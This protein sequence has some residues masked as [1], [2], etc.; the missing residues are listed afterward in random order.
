MLDLLMQI[1]DVLKSH[2]LILFGILFIL[3]NKYKNS[4]PFPSHPEAKVTTITT[5][6]EFEA[7]L[8]DNKVVVVDFF[9]Q[10]C[11]PCRACAVPYGKLSCEY[12]QSTVCFAK[13]DVD[14]GKDVAQ[15]EG[16]RSMPTFKIYSDSKCVETISGFR[17]AQLQTTLQAQGAKSAME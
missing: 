13:V 4:K 17:Q 7:V 16:I 1:V 8:K 15:K 5:M 12:D 10:W 9:A 3:Y 2:P 14:V 6:A 11:P